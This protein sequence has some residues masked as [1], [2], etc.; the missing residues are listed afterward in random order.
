MSKGNKVQRLIFIAL[1][2]SL[3]ACGTIHRKYRDTLETLWSNQ[4]VELSQTVNMAILEFQAKGKKAFLQQD[5]KNSN[6]I[7]IFDSKGLTLINP[8]SPE[9]IGISV[10]GVKDPVTKENIGKTMFNT[11]KKYG[12]SWT[13]YYWKNGRNGKISKKLSFLKKFKKGRKTYYIGS[14]FHLGDE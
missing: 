13:Q 1:L 10:I 4:V 2:F 9:N 3:T 8:N 5:L 7:F 14:G 11:A 12:S 6:Y